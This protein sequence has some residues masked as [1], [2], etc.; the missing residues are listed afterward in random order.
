[1]GINLDVLVNNILEFDVAVVE[2]DTPGVDDKIQ[3]IIKQFA[4]VNPSV[5]KELNAAYKK[6]GEKSKLPSFIADTAW[7]SKQQLKGMEKQVLAIISKN[8]PDLKIEEKIQ[9]QQALEEAFFKAMKQDASTADL[10]KLIK[11]GIDLNANPPFL[12]GESLISAVL[13]HGYYGEQQIKVIEFFLK[14]GAN[15]PIVNRDLFI[16]KL[17]NA[18]KMTS[19]FLDLLISKGFD[20]DK[21]GKTAIKHCYWPENVSFLMNCGVDPDPSSTKWS[22]EKVSIRADALE[23]MNKKNSQNLTIE[24]LTW[25][26]RKALAER[27]CEI[28]R[29]D[30]SWKLKLRRNKNQNDLTIKAHE[31]FVKALEANDFDQAGKM[32]KEGLVNINAY[33][34]FS[35]LA[36]GELRGGYVTLLT[37]ACIKGDLKK[38]EWLLKSGANPRIGHDFIPS[39]LAAAFCQKP[40]RS[41]IMNLLK[42]AGADVN[43]PLKSIPWTQTS[44]FALAM[45]SSAVTF[46][47][48]EFNP[49]DTIKALLEF[50]L[51]ADLGTIVPMVQLYDVFADKGEKFLLAMAFYGYHIPEEIIE[52]LKPAAQQTIRKAIEVRDKLM[53]QFET[54]ELME[55]SSLKVF[56]LD[57][58]K[59]IAGY[60]PLIHSLRPE[61]RL[62]L[63]ELCYAAWNSHP[64]TYR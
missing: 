49:A 53:L 6:I 55:D 36:E 52:K 27:C 7:Y 26:H 12:K 33:V 5:E 8:F 15:I 59:E 30:A 16:Q 4:G 11:Q 56:S 41:A 20:I 48:A 29:F 47:S 13:D 50:G 17:F 22:W 38:V 42:E 39:I 60:Q 61:Q 54:V 24:E 18:S 44:F 62:Q 1:M 21:D 63:A 28:S 19:E 25:P 40:Q 58:V 45:F 3:K 34:A 57:L 32:L 37:S 31:A 14:N 64:H 23:E 51:T 35:D 10:E 43:M 9:Q 46:L 2:N